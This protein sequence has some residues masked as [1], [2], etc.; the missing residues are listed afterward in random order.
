M[1]NT[2]SHADTFVFDNLPPK[3]EWPELS[4][5]LPQLNYPENLNVAYELLDKAV[6]EGFGDKVAILSSSQN[7][8]YKQVQKKANQVAKVLVEDF[9]LKSGNR[10]L[11]RGPNNPMMAICWFGIL[12][13]GF[14]AVTTMSMLRAHELK[15]IVEKGQISFAIT[16]IRLEKELTLCQKNTERLETIITFGKGGILEG[17]MDK[18]DGMFENAN[19]QATDPALLA[20]TSGTTGDPKACI[21]FHN[22]I[23]SMAHT[24]STETLKST[25]DEVFAGTPPIAFTFGLGAVIVFP[26]HARATTVLD[27]TPNPRAIL[28]AIETFNITTLF[29][30]PTAYRTMLEGIDDHDISSLKKCISAGEALSK[31]TSDFWFKETG[32]RL[33]DGIGATELIHIFISASGGDIRPGSTGKPVPGYIATIL[34][35]EGKTLPPGKIGKLAVK[36]PTGCKYLDDAR[37]KTYVKGGWNLTGDAYQMDEGGYF[38]FE[39]RADDMIISS[40]YNI[41]GP[42]VEEA[43]LIHPSVADCAVIGAPHEE[44]GSIVKAYIVLGPEIEETD[45]LKAELQ[46][47][48]KAAIAPYK[49]PRLISFVSE[50]PKTQTG[51]TQRFKL[52]ELENQKN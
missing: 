13:A 35:E 14:V 15:A 1:N 4:F 44:R 41:A 24:F 6:E 9:G 42:E 50:L 38:W 10:V 47:F 19:T 5:D 16:D 34:D 21:H 20:F 48:T 39:A 3:E 22:D 31:A 26:F 11:L 40:G 28:K 45:E 29:T 27:E 12:K 32:L 23:M 8:T 33:I 43:L 51:K 7:F 49:Y 2:T 36:G 30:A 37:Q 17:K 18:K 46:N 52:R 25:K